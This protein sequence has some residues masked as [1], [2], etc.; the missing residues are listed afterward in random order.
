MTRT[1]PSNVRSLET[2]LRNLA[3]AHAVP[4]RRVRRLIG[5]VVLG[6]FLANTGC[7]AIKGASNIEIRLGTRS[8]RVS[9]DLDTVRQVAIDKF[10]D[11]F[12]A[13]LREGWAGFTGVLV[14]D[15]EIATPAPDGY[16][17]HRY[18]AKLD[19][20][21]G[22]FGTVTVEV[23]AEEIGGLS[24][25]EAITAHDAADWFDELGLPAPLPVPT[26]PLAH[27]IAQKLH[28]CTTTDTDTWVNDRAHDLVDLQLAARVYRA[29]MTELR[30]VAARLFAARKAHTWPPQVTART[31]L[32]GPI[33]RSSERTSRARKPRRCHHMG[34]PVHHPDRHRKTTRGALNVGTGRRCPVIDRR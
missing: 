20:Q 34:Q 22:P 13:A 2:R 24:R 21:G 30:E 19:Y 12:A 6:Q 28:A 10:R 26:L 16:R 18:R 17:P 7:A 25:A 1:P 31:G 15:D 33:R 14:D 4:E 8:T 29:S 23:G 32:A 11:E 5:I 9:S 27:Q 3:R